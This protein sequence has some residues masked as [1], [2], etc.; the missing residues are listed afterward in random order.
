M[1]APTRK[2]G[3]VMQPG[4]K[5]EL[6]KLG[7]NEYFKLKM[8]FYPQ[9]NTSLCWAACVSMVASLYHEE[10]L[11]QPEVLKELFAAR[12]NSLRPSDVPDV[13]NF[14]GDASDIQVVLKRTRGVEVTLQEG[15][16]KNG[17]IIKYLNNFQPII[18]H[19]QN[20][21][22]VIG[23]YKMQD[24]STLL[25]LDPGNPSFS[26]VFYEDLCAVWQRTLIGPSANATAGK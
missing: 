8:L 14:M 13:N 16:L 6:K 15:R 2:K 3:N 20:H 25:M 7:G 1:T 26:A 17:E 4:S 21:S 23:G 24:K 10:K 5:A 9:E 11:S 19:G 12:G 22:K 18:A